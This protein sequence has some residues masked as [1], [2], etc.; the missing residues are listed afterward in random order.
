MKALFPN[1]DLFVQF[2][3]VLIG[4]QSK[5]VY[6][7]VKLITIGIEKTFRMLEIVNE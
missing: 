7:R 1:C 3:D 2:T 5:S 6:D 4:T